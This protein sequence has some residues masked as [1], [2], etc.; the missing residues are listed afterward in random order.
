LDV[1][2]Q[3]DLALRGPDDES[4]TDIEPV[5]QFY[6]IERYGIGANRSEGGVLP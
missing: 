2:G 6:L 5:D 4:I 1:G 3:L